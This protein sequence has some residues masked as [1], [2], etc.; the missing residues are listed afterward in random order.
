MF[1]V[2]GQNTTDH[3]FVVVLLK[4]MQMHKQQEL[5]SAIQHMSIEVH[6]S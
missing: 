3:E 5:L 2:R 4:D 1:T 6:A